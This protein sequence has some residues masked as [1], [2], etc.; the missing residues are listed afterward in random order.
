MFSVNVQDK[1]FSKDLI[2]RKF[3]TGMHTS[4]RCAYRLTASTSLR[5]ASP[6]VATSL[7]VNWDSVMGLGP[8]L[9]LKTLWTRT[10]TEWTRLHRWIWRSATNNLRSRETRL[11]RWDA[12]HMDRGDI[13][14]RSVQQTLAPCW[15]G[16]EHRHTYTNSR[17]IQLKY[18]TF[19]VWLLLLSTQHQAH[20]KTP[21][22]PYD[23]D[24]WPWNSTLF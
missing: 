6:D 14:Q 17:M 21:K 12:R 11:M 3:L 22:N 4:R 18:I 23:L 10:P 1:K 2:Q 15:N 16:S 8:R 20:R 13:Q 19:G 24:L 9:A 5:L 7:G